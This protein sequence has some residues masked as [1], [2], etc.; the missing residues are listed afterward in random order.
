VANAKPDILNHNIETVP[1]LYPEVR[2]MAIYERSL[3]LLNDSKTIDPSILTK[4]GIMLGLGESR[5]E[6]METIHDLKNNGCD[7]LTIGQYLPPSKQH[8]VL[9]EYIHPD[10]FEEYRI[11]ALEAG[12]RHVASG[13]LV[14]SSYQAHKA[15]L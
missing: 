7:F 11:K 3:N 8:H 10:I 14:R 12:F 13:P 5:E 9:V 15:L 1:R 4:S 6:V 2:P